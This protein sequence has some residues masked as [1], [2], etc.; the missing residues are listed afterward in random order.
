[1]ARAKPRVSYPEDKR[2]EAFVPNR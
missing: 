2:S 1:M